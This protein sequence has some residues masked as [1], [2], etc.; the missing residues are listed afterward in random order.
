[1]VKLF[2]VVC[3]LLLM[4]IDVGEFVWLC[5]CIDEFVCV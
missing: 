3:I 2:G 5:K 1:M 4:V